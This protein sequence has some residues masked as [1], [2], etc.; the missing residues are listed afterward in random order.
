MLFID[1][2]L[3]ENKKFAEFIG[4]ILGDGCIMD[5]KNH[6]ELKITLHSEDDLHY[7]KY[8]KEL[9][10]DLFGLDIKSY[11]RKGE[12]TLD[13][14]IVNKHLIN[15]LLCNVGLISSPKKGRAKIPDNFM[16]YGLD[17]LRG[18]FDTD[19]SLVTTNNNGTIYPRLEM[20]ICD[21]PMQ[22][23]FIS[24]LKK[25]GFRYRAYNLGNGAVRVQMNGKNQLK[26]WV[27]LIGFNNL[28]HLNKLKNF[29]L[30][31]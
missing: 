2:N 26:K 15:F 16:H 21:S 20:K 8:L 24:L 17:V 14:R 19:G 28:K 5:Y 11:M 13:L 7:S 3:I 30:K 1:L 6:K 22:K 12:N 25:N 29:E 23:Q 31:S 27:N 10:F 9:F 18:Y 4:V